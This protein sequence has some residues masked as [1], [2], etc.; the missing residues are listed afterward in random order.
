MNRL[1]KDGKVIRGFV[2][3]N[4]KDITAEKAKFYQIDRMD[5]TIVD[6]VKPKGPADKAG[7][8][9]GDIIIRFNSTVVK[10][11]NH[12]SRLVSLTVPGSEVEIVYLRDKKEYTAKA[13]V[14]KVP[15]KDITAGA[16]N[17]TIM[18]SLLNG[19]KVGDLT[20][21]ARKSL[22]A[23]ADI[24]G[25]LVES[26]DPASPAAS[27]RLKKGDVIQEINRKEVLS[28]SDAIKIAGS[29]KGK[30]IMLFVWSEGKTRFISIKKRK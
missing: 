1:V 24:R 18:K 3:V 23:P 21:Q 15:E 17:N 7:I 27:A 9:K 26:V 28:A 16:T 19:V 5:G 10:N 2:G 12:L 30:S 4:G 8:K 29:I 6:F 11:S 22:G 13:T 25:A 14:E 20:P